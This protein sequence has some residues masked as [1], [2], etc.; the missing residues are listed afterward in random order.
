LAKEFTYKRPRSTKEIV[1]DWKDLNTP[2]SELKPN[3]EDALHVKEIAFLSEHSELEEDALSEEQG[4]LEKLRR[5]A[6]QQAIS[7]P[8][9]G[10][11][12]VARSLL[13]TIAY[14]GYGSEPIVRNRLAFAGRISQATGQTYALIATP[15]ARIKQSLYKRKLRRQGELPEQVLASRM[16]RLNEL[17]AEIKASQ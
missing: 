3:S 14:Y 7:G 6:A 1:A 17:E 10:G 11:F 8:I 13:S 4:R 5:V 2:L 9:I 16:K 15:T 12:N